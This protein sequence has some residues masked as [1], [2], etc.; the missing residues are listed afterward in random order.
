MIAATDIKPGDVC[1]R[2]DT[3]E[4][5]YEVQDVRGVVKHNP[6]VGSEL[7]YIEADCLH[8]DGSVQQ[9]YWLPGAQAPLSRKDN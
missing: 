2:T 3:G 9:H 4:L 5:L 6:E 1:R 7:T 8:S